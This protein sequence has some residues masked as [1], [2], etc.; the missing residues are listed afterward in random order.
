KFWLD[1]DVPEARLEEH[2]EGDVATLLQ[3][4]A[5][6]DSRRPEA[7]V[8]KPI[9]WLSPNFGEVKENINAAVHCRYDAGHAALDGAGYAE[10][11][12][13]LLGLQSRVFPER[14][15]AVVVD[16]SIGDFQAGMEEEAIRESSSSRKK[17]AAPTQFDAGVYPRF[18]H[19]PQAT[20][21]FDG[22]Y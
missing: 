9:L 14:A 11:L 7:E 18:R 5:N 13:D 15:I 16:R 22:D 3:I 17:L 2:S 1:D 21:G 6:G 20:G 10:R 8:G 12:R 4:F 19:W